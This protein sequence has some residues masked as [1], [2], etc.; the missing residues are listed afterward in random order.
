[1]I[2]VSEKSL[3]SI[4][5][6]IVRSPL[7]EKESNQPENFRENKGY[8][9]DHRDIMNSDICMVSTEISS[10]QVIVLFLSHP[11]YCNTDTN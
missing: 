4:E 11:S 9:A 7:L 1:M 10:I 6:Y 5:S 3:R 8:Y 2:G